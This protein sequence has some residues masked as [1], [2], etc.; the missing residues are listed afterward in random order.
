MLRD[1]AGNFVACRELN[2]RTGFWWGA[3]VRPAKMNLA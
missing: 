3:L 2:L 1:A